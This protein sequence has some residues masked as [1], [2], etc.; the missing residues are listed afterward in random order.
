MNSSK[1]IEHKGVIEEVNGKVVRVGIQAAS[2]CDSCHAKGICGAVDVQDKYV[3]VNISNNIYKVGEH[4]HVV[5]KQNEGYK[6]LLWGYLVPLVLVIAMLFVTLAITNHEAKSGLIALSSLI[7]YYAFLYFLRNR[8]NNSFHF[9]I[10]KNNKD[11]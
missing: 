3:D 4:V 7:P 8:L 6:A 1:S 10:K 11:E 2:A 9:M 5:L